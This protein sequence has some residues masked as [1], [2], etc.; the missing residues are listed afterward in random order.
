MRIHVFCS[1][2]PPLPDRPALGNGLRAGQI[3]GFLQSRG[4]QVSA[5]V[6]R[7]P[8]TRMLPGLELHDDSLESQAGILQRYGAEAAYCLSAMHSPLTKEVKEQLSIKVFF[9]VRGPAF[10]EEAMAMAGG[11]LEFFTRFGANLA[12]AD[13][14]TVMADNQVALVQTALASIGQCW[15]APNVV[16]LPLDLGS[17][18]LP[19]DPGA[20]P[21]FL[22]TGGIHPWQDSTQAIEAVA[23]SL[24]AIG[25]GYL[26]L[27]NGPHNPAQRESP[28]IT[29]WIERMQRS[30]SAFKSMAFLPGEVLSQF[31]AR[32]WATVDLYRPSVERQMAFSI[33]AWE[34]LSL[35]LPT[36]C[37]RDGRIAD[38]VGAGQAG[39]AVD[40]TDEAAIALALQQICASRD[41]VVRR[42]SNA[43][44]VVGD[45]VARW[46]RK[47]RFKHL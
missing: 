4:H 11:E 12:V 46:S 43:A 40:P 22:C 44:A 6:R 3:I 29:A 38:L 31:Y 17:H 13:E 25:R 36:L 39:W 15:N 32:A 18:A 19:R 26:L 27:V 1:D 20:E 2:L 33:Q 37:G 16:V 45:Y 30:Y 23:R 14:V 21:L 28:S 35:G 7:T 34:Q 10:L 9:D 41:E 42:G 24:A 47:A 5:S 8:Q